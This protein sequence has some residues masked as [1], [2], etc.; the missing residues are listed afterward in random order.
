MTQFY[1][2]PESAS[3]V[4][5]LW[6]PNDI[7]C[8]TL[9]NKD[10][11]PRQDQ[12]VDPNKNL[13]TLIYIL[14]A[15]LQLLQNTLVYPDD[16]R[17]ANNEILNC[18]RILTRLMPFIYEA[19]HLRDWQD[20]FFWQMRKPTFFWD[21]KRDQ[22]GALFDGL[23]P[24]KTYP[25]EEYDSDIGPPLGE[26]LLELMINFLFL[27]GFAIPARVDPN[28]VPDLECSVRVWQTGIGS[29]RSLGCTKY[30]EKNQQETVRLLLAIMSRT[31]YILPSASHLP[32]H[33]DCV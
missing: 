23:N 18:M 1:T 24:S 20:R 25:M 27:P 32:L 14:I 8:L 17:A 12:Q 21:K 16:P 19:E 15:R 31:M 3:D 29:T 13:E 10:N 2:L 7:G 28:R 4:F 26:T 33:F 30:H 9:N 5:S 6:S 11:H 22:P